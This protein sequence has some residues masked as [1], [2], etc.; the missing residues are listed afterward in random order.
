MKTVKIWKP[1]AAV[2]LV[3]GLFALAPQVEGCPIPVYQYALENWPADPY[4]L[5]V[6][7]KEDLNEAQQKVLERLQAAQLGDSHQ[8]A[9]VEVLLK[10]VADGTAPEGM[11]DDPYLVVRYP[12]MHGIRTP[13]WSGPLTMEA[14]ERLLQ[15]PTREQLGE[16]L[17]NRTSGVWILL[18]SGNR[19]ADEAVASSLKETLDRLVQTLVIPSSAEWGGEEVTIDNNLVFEVLRVDRTDPAEQAL[20]AMLMHSEPDLLSDEFRDQPM[21][22]PIYGRGLILY[23][24]I[25]NGINAWTLSE[26]GEFLAGPCSCQIKSANPG[27]DLLMSVDWDQLVT[28]LAPAQPSPAG[29]GGFLRRLDETERDN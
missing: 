4:E 21:V 22:F 25:G 29:V 18:E 26:A 9:N 14:V 3:T 20:V 8:L 6:Y 11:G 28:P 10:P 23:A 15:S 17:A 2:V 7:H 16:L 12:S 24:L 13:V 19:R 27:T 5:A 1:L